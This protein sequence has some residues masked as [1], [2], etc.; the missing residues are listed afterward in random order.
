MN[1]LTETIF[2]LKISLRID[3]ITRV[4]LRFFV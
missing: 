3:A 1:M 4:K 2:Y